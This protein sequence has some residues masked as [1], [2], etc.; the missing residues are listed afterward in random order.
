MPIPKLKWQA[1]PNFG[2]RSRVPLDQI[3]IHD[4]EGGYAGAIATFLNN[5]SKVSAHFVVKEDGYEIT[6][7]VKVIDDA[8][9]AVIFNSRSIGVELAGFMAKGLGAAEWDEAAWFTA[10]LCR[11]YGIKPVW[12]QG[13]KSSGIA[14]HADLGAAGGGHV[15]PTADINGVWLPFI[16]NVG[17]IYAAN[18]FPTSAEFA[19]K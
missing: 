3:I 4:T 18:V 14:R 8:W 6:Q 15:D 2:L 16:A 11:R 1:S 7:M 13:G 5:H 12:A 19:I 9:H 10:L 17:K